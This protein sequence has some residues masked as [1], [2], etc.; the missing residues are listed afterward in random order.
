[1]SVIVNVIDLEDAILG[2]THTFAEMPRI[3]ETIVIWTQ[4]GD[5]HAPVYRIVY[6]VGHPAQHD[7]WEPSPKPVLYTKAKK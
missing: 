1:M 2:G 5:K 4:N 6:D 7:I 3:G